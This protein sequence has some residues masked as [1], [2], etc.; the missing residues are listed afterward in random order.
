MMTLVKI[1]CQRLHFLTPPLLYC[2]RQ[3]SRKIDAL[4]DLFLNSNIRLNN[5]DLQIYFVSGSHPA[6]Y[7]HVPVPSAGENEFLGRRG[8]GRHVVLI[9]TAVAVAARCSH[10][11]FLRLRSVERVAIGR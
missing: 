8:N 3:P 11:R 5:S 1:V 2:F 6:V 7:V 9:A 4:F 10:P